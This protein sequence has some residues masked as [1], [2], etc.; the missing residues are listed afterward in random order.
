MNSGV[1]KIECLLNGHCYIG[2]TLTDETRAKMC[3]AQKRRQDAK[4]SKEPAEGSPSPY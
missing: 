1:Y 3:A 4:N 2:R